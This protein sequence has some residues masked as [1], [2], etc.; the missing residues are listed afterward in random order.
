MARKTFEERLEELNLFKAKHGHVR[1]TLK[2]DKSLAAFCFHMR[3]ARRC[4][5]ATGNSRT[6]TINE[7]RIKALDD[8]GFEWEDITKTKS[9]E[10]RLEDLNAFKEKHG[11]VRV[12]KRQDKSLGAF[13]RDMKAARR[14]GKGTVVMNEDRIKALD[15]LGFEWG[16]QEIK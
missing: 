5:R 7:D 8:L 9:F 3:Y 16:L 12:T 4:C 2:Q 14:T 15:E 6:M 1:V 10:E 11:N 13:C